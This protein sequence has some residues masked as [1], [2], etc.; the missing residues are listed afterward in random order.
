MAT[1]KAA[2]KEPPA[3]AHGRSA[4]L[5]ATCPGLPACA[6]G[7]PRRQVLAID[8][9]GWAGSSIVVGVLAV[10]AAMAVVHLYALVDAVRRPA[11]DFEG[12]ALGRTGWIVVL[13]AALLAV[14]PGSVFGVVYVLM[15]RSAR[16]RRTGA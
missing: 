16:P 1:G 6:V 5:Q 14:G 9:V 8:G 12:S 4:R 3:F 10:M 11:A 15:R 7:H 2:G 13:A